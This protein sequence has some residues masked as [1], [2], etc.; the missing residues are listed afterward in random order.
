MS[1][2]QCSVHALENKSRYLLDDPCI[3]KSI[4]LQEKW[5]IIIYLKNKM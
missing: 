4:V 2:K 1:K 5:T 3:W